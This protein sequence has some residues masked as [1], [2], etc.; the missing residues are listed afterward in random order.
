[1]IVLKTHQVINIIFIPTTELGWYIYSSD[2]DPDS[3]QEQNLSLMPTG[4]MRQKDQLS[5]LM[6]KTKYDEVWE[7][8]V[9][10]LDNEGYFLQ[11][12]TPLEDMFQLAVIYLI[13]YALKL[14]NV[15]PTWEDFFIL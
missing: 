1:M 8:E 7:A 12:I 10:Y 6:S 14:K 13:R 4:H 3:D 5:H 11:K 15:H 9:R 2:N